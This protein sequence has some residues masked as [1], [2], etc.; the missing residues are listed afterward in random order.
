MREKKFTL[1]CGKGRCCPTVAFREDGSLV[2]ADTDNGKNEG[3]IL[4]EEQKNQLRDLL[5]QQ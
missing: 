5:N 1:D 2:L 4:S 3:I